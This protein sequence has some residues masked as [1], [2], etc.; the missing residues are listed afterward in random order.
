MKNQS[1]GKRMRNAVSGLCAAWAAERSLRIH[2]LALLIVVI[3]LATLRPGPGWTA[4]VLAASAAVIA[5]EL[6]NTAL[7]ALADHLHPEL[8]P[9]IRVVKDCAAAAVLV[10]ALGA[11]AVAG[12]LA[13]HLLRG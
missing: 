5:A 13:V 3:A 9:K 6:F 2:A 7:E 10:T 1:M 11:V 8:H 12:A 4:L